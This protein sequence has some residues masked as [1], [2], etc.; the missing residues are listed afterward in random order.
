MFAEQPAVEPEETVSSVDFK[1]DLIK[2]EME[3]PNHSYSKDWQ[4][5][6][7]LLAAERRNNPNINAFE[8]REY[9]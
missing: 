4:T 6:R 2:R 5:Y 3:N 9:V 1:R 8:M 7:E